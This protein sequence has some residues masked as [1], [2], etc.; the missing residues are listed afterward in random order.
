MPYSIP[1]MGMGASV[2][3]GCG[4]RR[5][6]VRQALVAHLGSVRRWLCVDCAESAANRRAFIEA[7]AALIGQAPVAAREEGD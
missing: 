6:E 3:L 5:G 4:L 2:C 7:Y 1:P